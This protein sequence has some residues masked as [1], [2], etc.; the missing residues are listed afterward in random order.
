MTPN[1]NSINWFEIPV[2][3]FERAK[4]FYEYIFDLHMIEMEIN[5]VKM[6][7]FPSELNSRKVHGAL[8]QGEGYEPSHK[9]V[10]IYLNGNPD[11]LE[12]LN[13]VPKAGGKITLAKTMINEELGYMAFFNDTEGNRMALHSEQ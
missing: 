1:V 2:L 3:D 8:C 5:D 9:G 4:K 12:I 10:I 7:L 11:L 6:A 13:R